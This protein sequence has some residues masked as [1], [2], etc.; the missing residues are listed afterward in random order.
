VT[1]RTLDLGADKMPTY[2]PGGPA[3]A[4]PVLGLRSLRL[5]LRAP[6]LFRTQLRAILRAS[7]LGDVRVMFPLVTCLH[8][9]REARRLLAEVAAELIAEG[10]PIKA[11]LPVGAMI[12]VPAAAIMADQIARDSDFFSIGTNDLI[13]YTLAVDRTNEAVADLYNAADPAVLRLIKQV[14]D[15]AESRKIDVTVCGTMGGEPLHAL[16]L[17]GLGIRHL[18]MPPHQLPEMKRVIRAVR[19]D[20]A[21]ALATEALTMDTASAVVARLQAALAEAVPDAATAANA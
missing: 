1:I 9:L 4:N 15:A 8:E 7:A 11:D 3:E 17:L 21:R 14:V 12:E 18:S 10:V 5:S 19:S 13:Q 6:E 2:A 20:C 16:L